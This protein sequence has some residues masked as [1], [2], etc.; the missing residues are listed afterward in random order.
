MEIPLI[1]Y[2][3]V[4]DLWNPKFVPIQELLQL[5]II[6]VLSLL[7]HIFTRTGF[8]ENDLCCL[9]LYGRLAVLNS[10][11]C[12]CRLNLLP[13]YY[14]QACLEI[15]I[16]SLLFHVISTHPCSSLIYQIFNYSQIVLSLLI[17]SSDSG[18]L[19]SFGQLEIVCV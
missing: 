4:V 13:N 11:L 2:L 15:Q 7:A 17:S 8:L 5:M 10:V 16:F 3:V 6:K 12:N 1:Y 14:I 9:I 19:Y 18:V